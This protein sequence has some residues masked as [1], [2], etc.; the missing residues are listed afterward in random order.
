MRTSFFCAFVVILLRARGRKLVL[1]G[2]VICSLV[3]ILAGA[4]RVYLGYHWLSDVV[5]GLVLGAALAILV[6]VPLVQRLRTGRGTGDHE[7]SVKSREA[8]RLPG[9]GERYTM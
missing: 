2:T 3:A 1:L 4:S 5:A 7:K 8:S 9:V 6:T